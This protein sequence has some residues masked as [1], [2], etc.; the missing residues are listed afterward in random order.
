MDD[1]AFR[2]AVTLARALRVGELG[3]R[4]LLEHYVARVDRLNSRLN[5]VVA[6]AHARAPTSTAPVLR[7]TTSS[8]APGNAPTTRTRPAHAGGSWGRCTGSR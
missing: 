4:E 1:V 5:A 2:P 6:L 7:H 8:S 3:S